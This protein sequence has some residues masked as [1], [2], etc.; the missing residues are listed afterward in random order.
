M[1]D[2]LDPQD[3]AAIEKLAAS[4]LWEQAGLVEAQRLQELLKQQKS[5]DALAELRN[6][7]PEAA[8]AQEPCPESAPM[9]EI[10]RE[11]IEDILTMFD[12]N[13]LSQEQTLSLLG[14]VSVLIELVKRGQA[15][16]N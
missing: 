9:T 11:L 10:K 16:N 14:Q 7:H 12:D 15:Q 13:G 3:L 8:L 6:L 1:A 5:L 2:R 4:G